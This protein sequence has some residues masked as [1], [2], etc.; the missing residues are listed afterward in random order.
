MFLQSVIFGF[1]EI[2]SFLAITHLS[3]DIEYISHLTYLY[4][5]DVVWRDMT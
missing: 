1:E 2:V 5:M 3:K 4:Y